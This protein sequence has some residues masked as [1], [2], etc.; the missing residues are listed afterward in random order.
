MAFARD[1]KNGIISENPTFR[2][3]LGICPTL[4]VTTSIDNA[5]GMGLST[6]FVLVCSNIFISL[7]RNYIPSKIRIPAF[8]V[9]ISTFV[10]MIDLIMAASVPDIHEALGI[11]IPLIVVNCIIMGR[12]EA[13]ASKNDVAPS[14]ADGIGMGIGFTI[15]LVG[16]GAIREFIGSGTLLSHPVM[17]AQYRPAVIMLLPPGAFLTMGLLL[18]YF[19]YKA[20]R[21][22]GQ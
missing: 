10:T 14:I 1:V 16:I 13:F 22:K 6:A 3:V 20:L 21:R 2:L 9:I 19:R 11:F 7:V 17:T 15:A 18:C 5:L 12:A 8:I 4:A